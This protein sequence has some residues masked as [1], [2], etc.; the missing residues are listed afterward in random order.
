MF[1]P[2]PR[3]FRFEACSVGVAPDGVALVVRLSGDICGVGIVPEKLEPH[4]GRMFCQLEEQA[5]G[6][7]PTVAA[8]R[9]SF[10][11]SGCSEFLPKL[12]GMDKNPA[13]NIL[14][15]AR[16]STMP[17]T[18]KQISPH[19]FGQTSGGD[20]NSRPYPILWNMELHIPKYGIL[21]WTEIFVA[22]GDALRATK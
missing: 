3:S 14:V 21:V 4:I 2:R 19:N 16:I 13:Q 7:E 10:T 1:H 8:D 22:G 18:W 5:G 20:Q 6:F 11:G 17:K 9:F 12:Y 15:W